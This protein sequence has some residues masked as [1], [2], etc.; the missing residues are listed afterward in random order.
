MRVQL[1]RV[2]AGR[3]EARDQPAH[4]RAADAVDPHAGGLQLVEHAEVREGARA[5]ARQ[6]EPD[7][8]AGQPPR[9]RA[10]PRPAGRAPGASTCD[11]ARRQRVDRRGRARGVRR[12]AARSRAAPPSVP[13]SARR[14]LPLHTAMTRSASSRQKR[15]QRR[16]SRRRRRRAARGRGRARRDRAARRGR[17]RRPR[18]RAARGRACRASRSAPASSSQTSAAGAP[19][20]ERHDAE[21]ARAARPAPR[22]RALAASRRPRLRVSA[23]ANSGAVRTSS[24]NWLAPELDELAVAPRDH[25]RRARARARAARARRTPRRA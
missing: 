1:S 5:A 10:R 18:P 24:S 19:R 9:E 4:A 16:R 17:R 12:R 13:S 15:V 25:R 22:P 23:T 11:L 7:G 21:G 6:H 8:P 2:V 14:A 3:D 20:V